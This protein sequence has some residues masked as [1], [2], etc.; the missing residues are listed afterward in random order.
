VCVIAVV[1]DDRPTSEQV[2]QMWDKNKHGAGVAWRQGGFVH[3]KKGLSLVDVQK[4]NESLPFP[5]V[6][7]FR[8]P[9]HGTSANWLACHPF[10]IDANA[11]TKL[12]G[13]TKGSVLFHNGMWLKWKDELKDI[14]IR[15]H[16]KLPSGVWSDS[17]G[18]AW[19]AH[20]LG[21][22]ILEL[23]DEKVCVFGPEDTELFGQWVKCGR[24][25]VS[26]KMWEPIKNVYHHGGHKPYVGTGGSPNPATF[27][28]TKIGCAEQVCSGRDRKEGDEE[29][30]E[31]GGQGGGKSTII[32]PALATVNDI[33]TQATTG[34]PLWHP[35]RKK[36]TKCGGFK[37]GFGDTS[38]H[39]CYHCWAE[40]HKK[41]SQDVVKE[42][43][44]NQ[45]QKTAT[46]RL[47][48]NDVWICNTC[49][50]AAKWPTTY[51]ADTILAQKMLEKRRADHARGIQVI[52]GL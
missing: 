6:L 2:N 36:C 26:N 3:W 35:A 16:W 10:P 24:L 33:I 21:H 52:G 32:Q 22:G 18:L 12:E 41:H 46:R 31:K 9:S 47:V 19:A 42:G 27:R 29:G 34:L 37:P 15:G 1:Q 4:M 51:F 14:A 38:V 43:L 11:S 45:C 17:R 44:C 50:I 8:V 23:I 49:W 25:V 13:K 30:T 48:K 28:N 5:Y 39:K 40:D 20:H 7:H